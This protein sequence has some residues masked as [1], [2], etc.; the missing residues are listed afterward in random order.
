MQTIAHSRGY[1]KL[2]LEHMQTQEGGGCSP[3]LSSPS[4]IGRVRHP[5]LEH[6]PYVLSYPAVRY[7]TGENG[8]AH[9][10][11]VESE[12]LRVAGFRSPFTQKRERGGDGERGAGGGEERG[13]VLATWRWDG[14]AKMSPLHPA[15]LSSQGSAPSSPP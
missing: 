11:C 7:M 1:N 14:K 6:P 10:A 3:T 5:T 9:C 13:G 12:R 4:P 2:R 8:N 15:A